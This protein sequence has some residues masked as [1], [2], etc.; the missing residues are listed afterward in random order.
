MSKKYRKQDTIEEDGVVL[1]RSCLDSNHFQTSGIDCT[2]KHADTDGHIRLRDGKGNYTDFEVA[3]QVKSTNKL[4]KQ[5][6]QLNKDIIEFGIGCLGP[7]PLFVPELDSKSVYCIFPAEYKASEGKK[8]VSVDL[9]TKKISD[10]GIDLHS[11]LLQKCNELKSR[12][13]KNSISLPRAGGV[14][15]N[16]P[17]NKRIQSKTKF[18]DNN[19]AS[20]DKKEAL[21]LVQELKTFKTTYA[22]YCY[23]VYYGNYY[24]YHGPKSKAANEYK[25]ATKKDK[26]PIVAIAN[27]GLLYCLSDQYNKAINLLT[28]N[29]KIGQESSFFFETIGLAYSLKAYQ[30]SDKEKYLKI[31][32]EK[33]NQALKINKKNTNAIFNLLACYRNL[34]WSLK[35]ESFLKRAQSFVKKDAMIANEIAVDLYQKYR[36]TLKKS[37]LKEMGEVLAH[38]KDDM[39][40]FDSRDRPTLKKPR[41]QYN[42]QT[43]QPIIENYGSF[44]YHDGRKSIAVKLWEL[45]VKDDDSYM[46]GHHNLAVHFISQSEF[47]KAVSHLKKTK[48]SK[49]FSYELYGGALLDLFNSTFHLDNYANIPL[50]NEAKSVFSSAY[51]QTGDLNMLINEATCL[52][53]LGKKESAIKI[54]S[55]AKEEN[56]NH[57]FSNLKSIQL[58]MHKKLD[59]ERYIKELQLLSEKFPS[60]YD[61]LFQLGSIYTDTDLEKATAYYFT[62]LEKYLIH[63]SRIEDMHG[64]RRILEIVDF[65]LDENKEA[66]AIKVLSRALKALSFKDGL[67]QKMQEIVN[68]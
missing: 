6:F 4:K 3:I 29:E 66:E 52:F 64:Q 45:L 61:H 51:K 18:L 23:H 38:Y 41:N 31:A 42:R 32:V 13:S 62:A 7:F 34:G 59:N 33:F 37:Y 1:L 47:K 19:L 12:Q 5:K 53:L 48:K 30:G 21:E 15:S 40:S 16:K 49:R 24:L 35:Y 56:P 43:Y 46:G 22:Q 26:K 27:L 14:K 28:K 67:E 10:N 54:V 58:R 60:E 63:P 2:D 39:L 25:K 20:L 65:L 9:Q 36:K 8:S 68:N 11:I 57:Y 44:L 50:I 17:S 55:K